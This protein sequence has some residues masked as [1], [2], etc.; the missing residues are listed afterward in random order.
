MSCDRFSP[1]SIASGVF[2]L[3]HLANDLIRYISGN[4]ADEH[5]LALF[6]QAHKVVVNYGKLVK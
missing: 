6:K 4:T 1:R 3:P 5:L 2:S